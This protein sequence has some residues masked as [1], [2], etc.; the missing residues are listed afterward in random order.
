MLTRYC[1]HQLG[2]MAVDAS[3]VAAAC[4]AVFAALC[5]CVAALDTGAGAGTGFTLAQ[6]LF[7]VYARVGRLRNA[8]CA[9]CARAARVYPAS[10]TCQIPHFASLSDIYKFVF[11]YKT[12][13]PL[14]T[15]AAGPPPAPP[16]SLARPPR[17][18]PRARA[19]R[20]VCR[21]RRV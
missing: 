20:P 4:A 17:R 5:A 16:P 14:R 15:S 21:S 12:V 11:G 18:L 1:L 9:P 10:N 3:V 2:A 7:S 13:R 6:W 8:A 19:G